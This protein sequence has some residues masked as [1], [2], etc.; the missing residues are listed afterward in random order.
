MK[1]VYL[2][3]G[4][5]AMALGLVVASCNKMDAFNPYAEQEAKQQ[6]FT[7]NFQTSVMNGQSID[8]N[9]T[10][11]NT[12]TTQVSVTPSTSGTLKIYTANPIGNVVASL[13]T[14]SVTAGAKTTFT[15]AKPADVSEL[16]VAVISEKGLISDILAFDATASSVEVDLNAT[17]STSNRAPRR[18][19]SRPNQPDTIVRATLREPTDMPTAANADIKILEDGSFEESGHLSKCG[20]LDVVEILKAYHDC[21]FKGYLRPDH[22]RMIWGEK[23]KPGYGLYDRALGA[24]YMTGIWETL[25]KTSGK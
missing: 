7:E 10:W 21:N 2:M 8:Q 14:A 18:A 6:E 13:Y 16:Y 24:M 4:M 25:E 3:K 17:A 19:D 20:S 1:K 11:A 23:G 5:A 12:T 9:Q 22:G 15:V